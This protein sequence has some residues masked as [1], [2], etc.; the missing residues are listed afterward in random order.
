MPME[1]RCVN[2]E[3]FKPLEPCR[4]G[5]PG[6]GGPGQLVALGPGVP[7]RRRL[8]ECRCAAPL[9]QLSWPTIIAETYRQPV[10]GMVSLPANACP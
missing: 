9:M 4:L 3:T 8:P 2:G 1:G 10:S 5:S 7:P 6:T